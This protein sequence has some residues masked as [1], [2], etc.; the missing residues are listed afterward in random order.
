MPLGLTTIRNDAPAP[1]AS[2]SSHT[3]LTEKL[4]NS[5]GAEGPN[6]LHLPGHEDDL[7]D[8]HASVFRRIYR[9]LNRYIFE[10]LGTG[11][12]FLYL[13]M[14]FLPVI[15]TSPVLMLEW[16]GTKEPPSSSSDGTAGSTGSAS[17]SSAGRQ[18]RSSQKERYTTQLWYRFLVK[19]MELAGPTFIKLAQWA[20]SRRDLF[21][22]ELCDMFGRLH[23]NGKPHSLR[24]TKR[25]LE[26]A[27]N[28]PFAEIFEEFDEKP[29]GIGAIAQVCP[30]RD[31]HSSSAVDS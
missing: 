31:R 5:D 22:D 20:G 27:F 2:S 15:I 9:L 19:Q 3:S 7:E 8:E 17:A 24:Y 23:S 13:A 11:R 6:E 14:L 26:K 12:R 29:M 16:I 21:P 18:R 28:K 30:L 4:T 25:V 1:S 10:P